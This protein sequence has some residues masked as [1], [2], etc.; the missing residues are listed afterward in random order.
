LVY[1]DEV[2]V[3]S[4]SNTDHLAHVSEALTLL[5][6]A[7]LSLKLNKCHLFAETVDY[8]GHVFR[9]GRLGVAEKNTTA[10]KAAPLPCTQTELRSFL[11]LFNAYR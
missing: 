3:F 9:P 7:V 4:M 10:L 2:I 1:L 5:G 11:G 6:K 8:L